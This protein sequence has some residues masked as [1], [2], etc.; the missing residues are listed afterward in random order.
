MIVYNVYVSIYTTMFVSYTTANPSS[1]DHYTDQY[2]NA[3]I[4]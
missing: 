4:L 2:L 3:I 1:C